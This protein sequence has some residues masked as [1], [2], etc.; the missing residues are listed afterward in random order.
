LAKESLRE[1]H[2][3]VL[4]YL[5]ATRSYSKTLLELQEINKNYYNELIELYKRADMREK[6]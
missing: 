4:E 1:G 2:S 6:L 5:D 3:S